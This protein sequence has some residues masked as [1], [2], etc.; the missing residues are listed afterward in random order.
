MSNKEFSWFKA[1]FAVGVGWVVGNYIGETIT[2][3]SESVSKSIIKNK[4]KNGDQKMQQVCREA[5][6]K[7]EA[8]EDDSTKMKIG[9][10][11]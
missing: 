9:F 6:I 1:A 2:E 7:Y 3:L 10:H 8:T 11:V 4:A 5:G